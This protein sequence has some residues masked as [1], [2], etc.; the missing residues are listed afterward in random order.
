MLPVKPSILL[1]DDDRDTCEM[2]SWNLE[3][4]GFDVFAVSDAISALAEAGTDAPDVIVTD[5]TLPAIDGVTLAERLKASPATSSA[6]ILMLSGHSL[7]GTDLD[8]ARA[9]CARILLKPV[10]PD[11]LADVITTVLVEA[12]SARVG[13]QLRRI[14]RRVA[15]SNAD[16]AGIMAAIE[17]ELRVESHPAAALLAD[18]KGHYVE[19]S[20]TAT[21]LTGRTREDLLAMSVWDLTPG[22]QVGHGRRMWKDFISRGSMEGTYTL[23]GPSGEPL[24]M[25]FT[26]A[27]NIVPGLHLSLLAILPPGASYPAAA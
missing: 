25:W 14:E 1:V 20:V 17:E 15:G 23:N 24:T 4:R 10:L 5:Y 8:R 19:V 2:Y 16:A 13:A 3:V 9:T 7:Q 12:T 11:N 21:E 22:M 27:A 26:A 18:D 6:P